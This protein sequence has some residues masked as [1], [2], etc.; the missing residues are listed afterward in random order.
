MMF[1]SSGPVETNPSAYSFLTTVL[2]Q[3]PIKKRGE[4]EA[5]TTTTAVLHLQCDMSPCRMWE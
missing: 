1:P 2:G 5:A 3:K 4:A